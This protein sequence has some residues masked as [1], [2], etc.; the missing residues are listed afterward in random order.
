MLP[1]LPVP[2]VPSIPRAFK[3]PVNLPS[4]GFLAYFQLVQQVW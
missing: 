4:K 2:F 3:E 1:T